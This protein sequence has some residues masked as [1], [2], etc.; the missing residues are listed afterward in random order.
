MVLIFGLQLDA[1]SVVQLSGEKQFKHK[2][3]QEKKNISSNHKHQKK[4]VNYLK[5]NKFKNSKDNYTPTFNEVA[6]VEI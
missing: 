3:H 4:K 6:A 1:I 5:R 2:Q